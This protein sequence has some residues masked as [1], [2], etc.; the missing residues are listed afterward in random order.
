M[1]HQI[2]SVAQRAFIDEEEDNLF[3]LFYDDQG[4]IPGTLIIEPDATPSTIELID[5]NV[6]NKISIK[7]SMPEECIPYLDTESVSWVDVAGLGSEDILQRMGKVFNLHPI[8]IEDVVNVPQ[9]PKVDEYDEQLLIIS[10]MVMPKPNYSGFW[11]EQVSLILGKHYLLTVQEEPER[12][13]FDQVR[14]RI[15]TDKGNIRKQ[16]ADYLTYTLL[17]AIIDGFFPVLEAYGERIEELEDEVVMN[18]SKSTLEKIYRLRRELLALRRCIWPQRDAINILIRDGSSLISDEVKIYMRDCYD[19][20]VQVMDMVETYREL[21]SGLMDVYLSSVSNK[22]NEIMKLLTVI[23]SIFIP[24]T[25]IAG[26]YGM[27]FNTSTS[28]L[29]MPELDW[30]WGYPLCWLLMIGVSGC[31]VY[32]F[33]KRGWFKDHSTLEE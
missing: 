27:N 4:S 28:P 26:V 31:L 8:L 19:H 30:Y 22:M 10:Q 7:L 18:P 23:S 29:N 13:C 16:G 21:T 9:R 12:D 15:R 11:I 24:L 2:P 25:F 17:D 14:D 33:W 32:F 3:E 6:T 20:T 1:D 5:Y